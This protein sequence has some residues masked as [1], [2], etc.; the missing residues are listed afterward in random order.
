MR[1]KSVVLLTL[2]FVG[3]LIIG[4]GFSHFLQMIHLREAIPL[5]T[6]VASGIPWAVGGAVLGWFIGKY[7][8]PGKK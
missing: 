1:V 4:L 6:N 7:G 3:A 5:K 8:L 2:M